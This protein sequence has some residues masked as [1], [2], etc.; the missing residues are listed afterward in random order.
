MS[1][2]ADLDRSNVVEVDLGSP[3]FKANAHRYMAEW[4]TR[5]PFYVLGQGQPQVIVGRYADVH[6][7]F[8]D[9]DTFASEMP[10][11]P[12]WEQFNKIMDAQF[13]TQMDGAQHARVR[14]LLM[15]AFSAR[16]IEQLQA[17]I[18]K[19]VDGM[20][21]RID[22]VL[23]VAP[24]V[25]APVTATPTVMTPTLTARHIRRHFPHLFLPLSSVISLPF[26]IVS[27]ARP[28]WPHIHHL[29]PVYLLTSTPAR[30]V[31]NITRLTT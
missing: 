23:F 31:V 12:G 19:V 17:T 5:K 9:T 26:F 8:S 4:A 10:R 14:R 18:R 28:R 30:T 6:T 2:L 16:R 29:P 24:F 13:V 1:S 7:V 15:P 11:G 3:E 20:L 27:H 22:A 21:D 25:C